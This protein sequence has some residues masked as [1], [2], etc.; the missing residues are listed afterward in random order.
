MVRLRSPQE[1][2]GEKHL[3]AIAW[4]DSDWQ[5]SRLAVPIRSFSVGGNHILIRGK[6]N[7]LIQ[8]R[9]LEEALK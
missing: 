6:E 5:A 9:N 4:S 1:E 8:Y 7:F 2:P 3:P